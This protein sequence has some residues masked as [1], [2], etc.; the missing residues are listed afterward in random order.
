MKKESLV[1]KITGPTLKSSQYEYVGVVYPWH[2][3]R[4]VRD[5]VPEL[6]YLAS[7]RLLNEVTGEM[8]YYTPQI[9]ISSYKT[10]L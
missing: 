1:K 10:T 3:F 9:P 2:V 5:G 6:R 7:A 8:E 4:P